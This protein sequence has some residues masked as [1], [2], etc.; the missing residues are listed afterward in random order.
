[1][2]VTSETPRRPDPDVVATRDDL[3]AALTALREAAALTVRDVARRAAVPVATVGGYFSG[4]HVPPLSATAQVTAVLAVLGVTTEDEVSRW[5]EAIARVRRSPG[6]RPATSPS[7]Y[8]GLAAFERNDAEWFFGREAMTAALRDR[9]LAPG[10]HRLLMVVGASGA[11]KSSLLRAGLLGS[12]ADRS[13]PQ[14]DGERTDDGARAGRGI[15]LTP[16]AHP[17]AALAAAL[18]EREF[19]PGCVVVV[20]QAEELFSLCDDEAERRAFV[21][22]LGE[23]ADAGSA[24]VLGLR[25]DFYAEALRIPELATALQ[26]NQVVVGPMTAEELRRAVVG[27][28]QHAGLEVEDALVERLLADVAP[29]TGGRGA[30]E[31]GALPLLAHA[32]YATWQRGAGRRLT[33]ADYRATGGIDGAV[34]ATAEHVYTGLEP[35]AHDRARRLF[36]RMVSVGEGVADTRRAVPLDEPGEDDVLEAFL[37]ARLLTADETHVQIAHEALLTAWPRLTAWIDADRAGLRTHRLLGEAAQAWTGAGRDADLLYRGARL[38]SARAWAMDASHRADATDTERAFLAASVADE[39]A[40]ASAR[41]RRSRVMRG[42]VAGLAVLLVLAG[43]LTVVAFRQGG[44]AREQRDLARSRQAA[45][46]SD[47]LRESDLAPAGELALAAFQVAPTVEARSSLLSSTGA[48]RVARLFQSDGVAQVVRVSPNGRVLASAGADT[49]IRLW[50]LEEAPQPLGDPLDGGDATVFALAFSPDGRFLASGGGEAAIRLWD[51]GDPDEAALLGQPHAE[52]ASTVYSLAFSPDGAVLAAA[53]ADGTIHL[54]DVAS[55]GLAGHRQLPAFGSVAAYAVGYTADGTVLIGGGEDGTVRLWSLGAGVAPAALG[56]P[57]AGPGGTVYSVATSPDGRVLAA[58]SA[59]GLVALWDIAD[60]VAPVPI[61]EPLA[62]PESWVNALAFSPDGATLVGGSS[63]NLLWAWDT[64]TG[65][66]R[67]ALPHPLAV[68]SV[69]FLPDGAG[70]ATTANDGVVRLWELPGPVLHG[71]PASI[72]TTSFSDAG[73]LLATAARDGVRLWDVTVPSA[74]TAVGTVLPAPEGAARTSGA[75]ALSPD[76]RVLAAGAADGAVY[77]WDIEEPTHPGVPRTLAGP[78]D[79]IENVAFSADGRFLAAASDDATVTVWDLSEPEVPGA[80]LTGPTNYVMSVAF[81]P[82]GAMLAAG[83][84]DERVY[85][86]DLT[87]PRAPEALGEP[88]TG[89]T[90][91]VNAVA[92]SPDGRTLAAGGDDRSIWLWDV[93][94]PASPSLLAGPVT[95]QDGVLYMLDFSPDGRFLAGA[96]G[97]QTVRVWDVSDPSH[98]E[99]FAALTGAQGRLYAVGF[100]ADG[101]HLAT[102]GADRAVRIYEVD[103]VA[104]ASSVCEAAALGLALS[105]EEWARYLPGVPFAD[106]C[107]A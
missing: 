30:Y 54:W 44:A 58:G 9:V 65:E 96:A 33:V 53:A 40:A 106:P 95:W 26:D 16:G 73:G 23:V 64:G 71:T 3:A 61:G 80:R 74:P 17:L 31:A 49:E 85:L 101:R 60:P 93:G 36:L 88:L 84:V 102:A 46:A 5:L 32:V 12:L 10:A 56:A 14:G 1:M 75:A 94:E 105:E 39:A 4:R 47:A 83:S 100:S 67:A 104:A 107:P 50:S 15:L 43:G 45:M 72:F 29:R 27:P 79:L 90:S 98:P 87:D 89:A 6:R 103:P 81:S 28:A 70:L 2:S 55:S 57:L 11:G 34:A 8:R 38:E 19:G 69:A 66:A 48:P 51:L 99:R 52:V 42:L 78:T 59:S 13:A 97:D 86:W 63:D 92:F 35:G 7:P 41:T 62:G 21:R 20:D 82:D 77:L 24:V 25:A 76:G 91:Y 18:E 22:R 37:E 68:T